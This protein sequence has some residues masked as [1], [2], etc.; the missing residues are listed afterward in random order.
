MGFLSSLTSWFTRTKEPEEPGWIRRM[1][2]PRPG[3][4]DPKA[5]AVKEAA[6]ADVE[7]IEEYFKPRG[8]GHSENDL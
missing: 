1:V 2:M 5:E 7:V 8:P 3:P 6:A 4:P